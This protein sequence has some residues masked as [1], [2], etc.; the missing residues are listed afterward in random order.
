MQVFDNNV[1]TTNPRQPTTALQYL[2]H[3]VGPQDGANL[4]F[5]VASSAACHMSHMMT[6][7]DAL[8]VYDLDESWQRLHER[9]IATRK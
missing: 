3:K 4:L 5:S 7:Q 8:P 2:G 6:Q 9:E 1:D